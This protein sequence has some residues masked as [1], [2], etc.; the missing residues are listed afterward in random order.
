MVRLEDVLKKQNLER[1]IE[2]VKRNKG[3]SGVDGVKVTDLDAFMVENWARIKE[4]LLNGTYKPQAVRGVEIPKGNGKTR[5]LGIPTVMDRV[6]QQALNQV[7]MPIWEQEFHPNSYG[8]RP[9]K[10]A[11]KAVEQAKVYINEGNKFIISLDLEK[12]F[13]KVNHDKLMNLIRAK[14]TDKRILSLIRKFLNTGIMKGEEFEKREKGTPQGSPLSPLLANILLHELDIE[15]EKR[16]HKFVRYAD[17]ITIFLRSHT[18]ARRVL[19]KIGKFIERK[20]KL[21]INMEKTKIVR[22]KSLEILGFSFVTAYKKGDRGWILSISEKSWA[23][24]HFKLKEITRKTAGLSVRERIAKIKAL[25]RGYVNYFRIAT[26]YQKFKD[27][28]GWL[29]NRLRYCFWHDWKRPKKRKESLIK[30]GI[31]PQQAAAFANTRKG[32]WAVAQSP[33]MNT[34]ITKKYLQGLG[35]QSFT[36][37]Y[38]SLKFDQPKNQTSLIFL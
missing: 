25:M 15:M 19:N 17:D 37:Y 4:E 5:L 22:P 35:Y 13:D 29:R 21:S 18:A 30:L 12:F 14:I 38:V 7:I 16:G 8:F 6:I 36:D 32:G 34:S 1:A 9:N 24:L 33:I 10:S 23:T 11:Q 3:T 27:L 20:L 2:K 31:N 28:D 26:G